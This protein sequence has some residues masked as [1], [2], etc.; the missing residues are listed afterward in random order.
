MTASCVHRLVGAMFIVAFTVWAH[1][2]TAAPVPRL[3]ILFPEDDAYVS[4]L[5]VLRAS[6]DPPG[7]SAAITFF[8]DGRQLCVVRAA[9]FECEWE[10]GRSVD[11]HQIRVVATLAAGDRLVRTLRTKGLGFS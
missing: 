11:E 1:A 10:A 5:T 9:P 4:G 7:V 2:Q 6:L 3:S 8:A